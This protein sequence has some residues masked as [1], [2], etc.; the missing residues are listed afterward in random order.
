MSTEGGDRDL[1]AYYWLSVCAVGTLNC[2]QQK[3]SRW[4]PEGI[5]GAKVAAERRVGALQRCRWESSDMGSGA[6]ASQSQA[7]FLKQ[8]C[9]SLFLDRSTE[10]EEAESLMTRCLAVARKAST[11][12]CG[13][14]RLLRAVGL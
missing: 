3:G 4:E 2:C 12:G 11:G 1:G 9:Q 13:W 10:L 14:S 8:G 7:E 6:G 5:Q